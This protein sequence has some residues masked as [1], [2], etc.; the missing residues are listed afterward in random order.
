[1]IPTRPRA[2]IARPCLAVEVAQAATRLATEIYRLTRSARPGSC[3]WCTG[4]RAAAD[5]LALVIARV[6]GRQNHA[7][8][9]RCVAVAG[10]LLAEVEGHLMIAEQCGDVSLEDL[11]DLMPLVGFIKRFC[12]A[13]LGIENV[14]APK[15]ELVS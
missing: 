11:D 3:A 13:G 2:R 1:M 8:F 12:A 14:T 6:Q 7:E 9:V 15:P 10:V 5:T 4:I